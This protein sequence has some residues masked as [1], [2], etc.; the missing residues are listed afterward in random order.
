MLSDYRATLDVVND[1]A[2]LT[3]AGELDM[4]TS[5]GFGVDL[6]KAL[7]AHT[8]LMV[9]MSGVVFMDSTGLRVLLKA[10]T[11]ARGAGGR[12]SVRGRKRLVERVFKISGVDDLFSEPT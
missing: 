4:A 7:D 2:V 10:S 8:V 11:R 9:D 6:D 3:V 12:I 5:D 1:T